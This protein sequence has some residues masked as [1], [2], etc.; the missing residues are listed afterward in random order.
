MTYEDKLRD[1]YKRLAFGAGTSLTPLS[2]VRRMREI[3][4]ELNISSK[5]RDMAGWASL[6]TS[7]QGARSAFEII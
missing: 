6:T 7:K 3:R 5:P 4:A 2:D 1:E